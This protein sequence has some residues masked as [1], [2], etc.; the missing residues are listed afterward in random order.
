MSK[1]KVMPK[2]GGMVVLAGFCWNQSELKLFTKLYNQFIIT[3]HKLY[4]SF[5][6]SLNA[7]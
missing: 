6:N 7:I 2:Y 1:I 4:T 3:L 5:T